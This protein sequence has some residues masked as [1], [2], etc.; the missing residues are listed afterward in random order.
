MSG[1][2][3][4]AR[5]WQVEKRNGSLIA[6]LPASF[7][8]KELQFQ[9]HCRMMT[10]SYD[11]S[12]SLSL[13]DHSVPMKSNIDISISV[14]TRAIIKCYWTLKPQILNA[15][16]VIWIDFRNNKV[17]ASDL[18]WSE[19]YVSISL[20]KML[21]WIQLAKLSDITLFFRIRGLIGLFQGRLGPNSCTL[22]ISGIRSILLGVLKGRCALLHHSEFALLCFSQFWTE[23]FP[24]RHLKLNQ[25]QDRKKK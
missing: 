8:Y 1:R 20:K 21:P 24:A 19:K 5:V 11:C 25:Q 16:D 13:C 10:T 2:L 17:G 23:T 15:E 7:M 9:R 14:S 12:L 4:C 3:Q 6:M 18:K 22:F